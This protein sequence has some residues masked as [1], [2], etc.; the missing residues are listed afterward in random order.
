MLNY[1][2]LS[3]VCT[4]YLKFTDLLD[5]DSYIPR[6]NRLPDAM[7]Q[8]WIHSSDQQMKI[9][10]ITTWKDIVETIEKKMDDIYPMMKRM[11]LLKQDKGEDLWT[12]NDDEKDSKENYVY[13]SNQ[14][15]PILPNRYATN[16]A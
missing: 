11:M 6:Y 5:R 10:K 13:N 12:F 9:C 4:I 15:K 7:D 3:P 1:R 16:Q 8:G 2:L 14:V